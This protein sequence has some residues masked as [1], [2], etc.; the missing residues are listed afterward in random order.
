MALTPQTLV[1]DPFVSTVTKWCFSANVDLNLEQKVALVKRKGVE[2][3]TLVE[4]RT[5]LEIGDAVTNLEGLFGG[6]DTLGTK[7]V[8]FVGSTDKAGCC[9]S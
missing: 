6:D 2:Y 7:G 8:I 3:L 5:N 9:C 1:S 4:T